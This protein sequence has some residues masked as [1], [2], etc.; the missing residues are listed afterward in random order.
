MEGGLGEGILWKEIHNEVTN[1]HVI[2]VTTC[3]EFHY[4][5]DSEVYTE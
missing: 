5:G 4:S 2:S 1:F 3:N